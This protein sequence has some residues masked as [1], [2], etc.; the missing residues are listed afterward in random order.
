VKAA[1]IPERRRLVEQTPLPDF[2][3]AT[4]PLC[5]LWCI[6]GFLRNEWNHAFKLVGQE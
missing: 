3:R 5:M 6:P 2:Y 4:M 1:V